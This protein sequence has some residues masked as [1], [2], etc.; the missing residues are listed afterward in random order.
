ML[1]KK[2]LKGYQTMTDD[3]GELKRGTC[4]KSDFTVAMETKM[5]DKIGLKQKNCHFG[6]N[7]R[8]METYFL[9]I[10]YQHS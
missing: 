10:R 8:H 1:F 9:R 6:P 3:S 2:K 5:A 7:L 4:I